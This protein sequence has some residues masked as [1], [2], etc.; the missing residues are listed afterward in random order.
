M[1]TPWTPVEPEGGWPPAADAVPV[2]V[3]TWEPLPSGEARPWIFGTNRRAVS[4]KHDHSVH[5][6]RRFAEAWAW[7]RRQPA[8]LNDPE[9]V[10]WLYGAGVLAPAHPL[11]ARVRRG[12][13]ANP[14]SP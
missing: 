9:C 8:P 13:R 1:E 6:A 11:A 12:P 7:L 5:R 14:G 4:M 10:E 2:V 3:S